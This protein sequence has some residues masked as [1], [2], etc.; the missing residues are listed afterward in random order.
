M[1]YISNLVGPKAH[2]IIH[3]NMLHQVVEQSKLML[4][5]YRANLQVTEVQVSRG[6]GGTRWQTPTV[7]FVKINFNGTVFKDSNMSGI[8]VVVLASCSEKITQAYKV[9]EIEALAALKAL[10]FAHKLGF[11]SAILKGDFLGLIEALKSEEH[12]LSPLG[13]L[14]EDVKVFANNFVRLLYSHNKKNSN[15]VAHSLAKHAICISDFQ[16]RMED[17][18]LHIVSVLQSDVVNLL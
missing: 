15:S 8:G 10:S 6:N 11:R 18:S 1:C 2:N 17:A 14:V 4:A 16:V 5:Q 3:V 7:G 12:T 9:D 13:L